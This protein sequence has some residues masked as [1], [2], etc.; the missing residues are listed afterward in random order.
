[1]KKI[2]LLGSAPSSIRLAPFTDPEWEIWACSPG[3]YPH[4]SP[5]RVNAFYELHRWEPPWGPAGPKEWFSKDYIA[6]MAQLR[7]PVFMIEPVPEIPCSCAYPKDAM[8][9]KFGPFF[10]TSS[11]AWMMAMAIEAGATE[12]A[13][14]GVDMSHETEWQW[15]RQG[16]QYFI[17]IARAMGIKVT[18]PPESDLLCPPR[19]YGFC[20]VDPHHVKLLVRQKELTDRLAH[21][22]GE[23][24]RWNN[25]FHF[26]NGAL[27][28]NTYHQNTWIA[29]PT[30]LKL[31]YANPDPVMEE[32]TAAEPEIIPPVKLN[33]AA[34]AEAQA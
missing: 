31:A 18:L 22:Q 29:D 33:G 19:L 12:I 28:D 16:C 5:T 11:I 2:A 13:L 27:S 7:C 25:E 34:H 17:S 6:F 23:L 26:L 10:F 30:A 1:M 21:V 14:Y 20:E 8:L 3:A 24:Q 4:I 9:E 15:Q 32:L